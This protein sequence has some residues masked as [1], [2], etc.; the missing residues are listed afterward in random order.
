MQSH[1]IKLI[2][3][4]EPF[5]KWIVEDKDFG[6]MAESQDKV[7]DF[8]IENKVAPDNLRFK[9]VDEKPGRADFEN[10]FRERFRARLR[11]SIANS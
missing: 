8:L 7:I 2:Y 6:A 5:P 9:Y 4:N 10:M 11:D 3:N 1:V